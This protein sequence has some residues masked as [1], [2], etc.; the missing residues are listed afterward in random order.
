LAG[1]IDHRHGEE[2]KQYDCQCRRFIALYDLRFAFTYTVVS[3][4][5]ADDL[6]A[7]SE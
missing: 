1:E 2:N 4:L 3:F 7:S 5:W 6:I